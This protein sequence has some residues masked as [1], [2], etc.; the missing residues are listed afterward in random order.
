MAN[1]N[2]RLMD[3]LEM[4]DFSS[5]YKKKNNL[6]T[7]VDTCSDDE[8][9]KENKKVKILIKIFLNIYLLVFQ[10]TCIL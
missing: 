3:L 4:V 9:S 6:F 1:Y 7:D 10:Q 2:H 5:H 8:E